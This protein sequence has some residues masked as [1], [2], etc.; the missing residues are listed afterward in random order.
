MD[1]ETELMARLKR[2][3]E[4]ALAELYERLSPNVNALAQKLLGSR[5]EAEE[6]VQDTF[7]TLY[8]KADRYKVERQSPRAY[9]YTIARNNAFSRLRKRKA[10]PQKADALDVTD[11]RSRYAASPSTSP[12]TKD[13]TTELYVEKI[14]GQ[15]DTDER[16]LLEQNFY[17]GYTHA[18]LAERTD[19][20][21]GTVKSKLRRALLK[22]RDIVGE[23]A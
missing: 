14:L 11:A 17:L 5:E 19:M 7:L 13:R 8:R 10:R 12:S 1:I 15:L 9:I 20:P 21:L 22:L 16:E 2:G 4:Q 6:V 23:G 3:D 18:E